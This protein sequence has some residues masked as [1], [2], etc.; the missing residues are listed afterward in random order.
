M[1]MAETTKKTLPKE[2]FNVE[3]TNHELLKVAYNAYSA[4]AR[5]AAAKTKTRGEVRGGGAKPWRQKGTG[6]ARQG[7]RRAPQWTGGG[8]VFGPHPRDYSVLTSPRFRELIEET[9]EAVHEEAIKSFQAGE[10]EG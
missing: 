6:R 5:S 7:S 4:N 10:R 3:V 1:A 9:N 8:V 2:I